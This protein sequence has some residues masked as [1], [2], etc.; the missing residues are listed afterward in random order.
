M[1]AAACREMAT[2]KKGDRN[3]GID[4]TRRDAAR[5]HFAMCAISGVNP[6]ISDTFLQSM[7]SS[8]LCIYPYIP[9]AEVGAT[10]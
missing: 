10:V 5:Q 2:P 8:P 6:R 1:G 4:A 7:T 9:T 3:Q